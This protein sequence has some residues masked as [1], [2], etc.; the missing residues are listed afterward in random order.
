MRR[1]Q[2]SNC[3]FAGISILLSV[4]V[5]R[6]NCADKTV[7]QQRPVEKKPSGQKLTEPAPIPGVEN[8]LQI[9]P[10]IIS[11]GQPEGEAAF[12]ELAKRGVRVM[13]SVDGSPPEV[14]LAHQF[15]IR[16]VHVPI[17]YDQ[18][19]P[20][21]R[22]DLVEAVKSAGGLVF[23]HCHHGQHRGPAAAAYCGMAIGKL[24]AQQAEQ[25]LH[26]AGTKLDYTGLWNAVRQFE[27][28]QVP[29]GELVEVANVEP[30]TSA[31][32]RV[33]Q[34]WGRIESVIQSGE[35]TDWHKFATEA[36]LL[37]EEF[38]ELSRTGTTPNAEF[39]TSMKQAIAECEK[40]LKAT[41]QQD[42]A[43]V[44]RASQAVRQSCS[45][46]HATH[47]DR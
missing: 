38:R 12:E 37:T 1:F 41:E 40:L 18:I 39:K 29:A 19:G 20:Q 44:K 28:P 2:Y 47:R 43:S 3:L 25:A 32:V 22:S 35:V 26:D 14:K 24:S 10:E 11:G 30:I 8:L 27:P 17:S 33:D 15:G 21:Q 46:C 31:M 16:Y 7:A 9:T 23:I 45:D 5:F 6:A 4:F 36:L 42:E 13:I 34:H